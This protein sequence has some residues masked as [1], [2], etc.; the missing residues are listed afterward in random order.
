MSYSLIDK[1]QELIENAVKEGRI[2]QYILDF[3][4]EE[5]AR[6]HGPLTTAWFRK[7]LVRSHPELA[8]WF[9]KIIVLR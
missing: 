2:K 9:D 7:A 3:L 4:S 6:Y 5:N 8:D 1:Y